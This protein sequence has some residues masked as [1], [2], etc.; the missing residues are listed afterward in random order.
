MREHIHQS[1]LI[2]NIDD[3]SADRQSLKAWRW[4]E[5]QVGL[6]SHTICELQR[7]IVKTQDTLTYEQ[8][9]RFRTVHVTVGGRVCPSPYMITHLMNNWLL[10]YRGREP[11]VNHIAFEKIHPFVDGNGRTGR[12]LLWW[13]QIQNG[14]EP[15]LFKASEKYEKYYPLFR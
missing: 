10:D 12:M 8:R 14:E 6:N 7:R 1:N 11:L 15:T 9:G 5:K 3:L 4:L 2:E 13:Q